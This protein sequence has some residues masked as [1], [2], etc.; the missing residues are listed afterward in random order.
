MKTVIF[1]LIF[2]LS[3]LISAKAEPIAVIVNVNN[4]NHALSKKQL[5]DLYMGRYVAFPNQQQAQ[6]L[7]TSTPNDLK[8]SFYLRLVKMPLSRV[9]SYWSR[10]SFTGR[11][12]PPFN[13]DTEQTVIQYVG[14]NENAIG[15]VNFDTLANLDS[16]NVKVVLELNE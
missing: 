3:L 6:P 9:N 11:A 15:Y 5:I 8:R 14:E 4:P 2:T 13:K 16:K 7:D 10:V 1:S 12:S